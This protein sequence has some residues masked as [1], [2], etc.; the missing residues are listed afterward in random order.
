MIKK[1]YS[2]K[3]ALAGLAFIA[4]MLALAVLA[5]LVAPYDPAHI[6]AK[7]ILSAPSIS[8]IFGTDT[9]GRD[10][11][12]RVVYGS[13]ISLSIG[14]IAVGIAVLIGIFFGSVAG[15]Y[16]GGRAWQWER[17]GLFHRGIA[18][19]RTQGFPKPR[20]MAD[21]GNRFPTV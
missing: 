6:D 18:G 14:F 4:V 2:N 20:S 5:P 13:R 19:G 12:S 3:F 1:F 9:L 11:F 15:Y 8:H 16:G 17:P 7:N 21:I 10:I